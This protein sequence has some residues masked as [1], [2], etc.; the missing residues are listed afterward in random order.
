MYKLDPQAAIDSDKFTQYLDKS[1]KYTG[2]FTRA[3]KLVSKNKGSHGIGFTFESDDGG[4]TRFDIWTL[5]AAEKPMMGY[6]TLQAIMTC[7]SLKG[8]SESVGTVDRYDFDTKKTSKVQA[9][10]FADLMNAP[11]GLVLRNTE[12]EKM[13]DGHGTG[14]YA[15]RLELVCPYR[16]ADNFTAS[17]ILTRKT[18]AEKLDAVMATLADRPLRDKRPAAAHAAQHMPEPAHFDSGAGFADDGYPF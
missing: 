12:Y 11:I 4:T 5:D 6:K 1:G 3:E 16:A 10:I 8:L 2:K 13:R 15:W 18:K 17:E 7:L 14:Q 9:P